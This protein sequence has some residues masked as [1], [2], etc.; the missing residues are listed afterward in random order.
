MKLLK[1]PVLMIL[2]SALLL[3]S[4]RTEESE[5]INPNN[6]ETLEANSVVAG[7]MQ[8]VSLSDGSLDNII[9]SANCFTV[10]LPV[11]VIVNG[12]EVTVNTEADYELIEDILDESDD[13]TDTVEIVFPI[14]VTLSDYTE[15]TLNSIEEFLALALTCP[16]EG[17]TDP[18][19]ECLDFVYPITATIFNPVTEELE[20]V[21]IEN[22]E[23]LYEFLELIEEGDVVNIEFPISIVLADGTTVVIEDLEQ[24]EDVIEEAEDA[25]DEDDDYD[26]DDDDCEDCTTDDLVDL[27]TGCSPWFVDKLEIDDADLEDSYDGYLFTFTESGEILV[28]NDTDEFIGSWGS[29]GS[30]EAITVE[31]DIPELPDFNANWILHEIDDAPGEF[32]IDLRLGDDRLRFESDCEGSGGGDPDPEAEA[33]AAVLTDGAWFVTNYFDDVDETNLFCEY[34]FEFGADG[35]AVAV[36]GDETVEGEWDIINDDTGLDLFLDFG[37]AFPFDEILDDWE[38]IEFDENVIRLRDI[39]GGDGTEDLLTF[40]REATTCD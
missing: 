11:T 9:D 4:C 13:D 40:G 6:E 2:M 29:T 26:Y 16:D 31:I 32:E 17:E 21:V 15:V 28:E 38:V 36:A 14:T 24:L 33:L 39:S 8:R 1:L 12:I 18:D 30:G 3:T 34:T 5:V 27:I 20:T 35:T 10:N 37:E 23:Q 19:I 7:L 25:C 22:D